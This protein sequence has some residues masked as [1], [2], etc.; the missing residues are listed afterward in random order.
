MSSYYSDESEEETFDISIS[1]L[2][3]YDFEP[4]Q[5]HPTQ[6]DINGSAEGSSQTRKGNTDW[7]KCGKCRSMETKDESK[8][9]REDG[10][11]P[12]F[13]CNGKVCIT[14]NESFGA[15]CIQREV[16][17]TVL[18]MLNN[19]RGDDIY[20]HNRS[21]RYAGYR[22]YTWWVHN[23]LDRGVCK[24]IPSCAIWAIRD[25]YPELGNLTYVPFQE[26]RDEM[27]A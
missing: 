13:Y 21:L 15:V 24:A 7:C 27:N 3:P 10:E 12:E 8:C 23:R 14:E 18:H 19:M 5:S 4:Q 11:V 1:D 25:A 2:R 9:C 26:V 6:I 22:Q 17:K 20:I 16:L